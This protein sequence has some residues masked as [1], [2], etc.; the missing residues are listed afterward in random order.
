MVN[1]I[2]VTVQHSVPDALRGR[3]MS[4]YVTVFAGTAPIGGLFAGLIADLLDAPT[5]FVLGGSVAALFL[6]L[7]AWQLVVRGLAWSDG[8]PDEHR[9]EQPAA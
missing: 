1:T 9:R 7:A 5:A 3:V 6:A 2:N 4:F 8:A